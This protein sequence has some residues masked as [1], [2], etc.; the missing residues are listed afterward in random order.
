MYRC[1]N[2]VE[3]RTNEFWRASLAWHGFEPYV[4]GQTTGKL[5]TAIRPLY[6]T[7]TPTGELNRQ[8]AELGDCIVR[9]IQHKPALP[10]S[11]VIRID[12]EVR[13][14]ILTKK[15]GQATKAA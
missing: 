11:Q 8:A 1:H 14:K 6:D 4:E 9:D 2:R 13:Q 5:L 3:E 12:D 7:P 15:L 10:E